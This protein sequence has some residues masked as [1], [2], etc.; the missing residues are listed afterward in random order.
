MKHDANEINNSH[1]NATTGN[2]QF[3]AKI[4]AFFAALLPSLAYAAT[5]WDNMLNTILGALNGTTLRL[6]AILVIIVM[7]VSFYFGKLSGRTAGGFILGTILVFGS[8]AIADFFIAA[9]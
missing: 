4:F 3:V 8:A 2:R 1:Q 5:P 6:I 9:V 7:G